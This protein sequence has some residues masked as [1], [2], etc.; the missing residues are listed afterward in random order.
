MYVC[1]P[2]TGQE[3]MEGCRHAG[4]GRAT[5]RTPWRSAGRGAGAG[6]KGCS[7]AAVR[8]LRTGKVPKSTTGKLCR[9]AAIKTAGLA[10]AGRDLAKGVVLVRLVDWR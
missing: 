4:E 7:D 5:E 10:F 3:C 6:R 8:M 9:K 2:V 1:L